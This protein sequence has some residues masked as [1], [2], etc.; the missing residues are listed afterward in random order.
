[1]TNRAEG[2]LLGH[3]LNI[4]VV[5]HTSS[6]SEIQYSIRQTRGNAWICCTCI[7]DWV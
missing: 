7:F 3:T 2:C 4:L 6:F 5:R 1:M